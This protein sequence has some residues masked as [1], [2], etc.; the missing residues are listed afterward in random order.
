MS[1][2]SHSI[3]ALEAEYCVGIRLQG[4]SWMINPDISK[5]IVSEF[6]GWPCDIAEFPTDCGDCCRD[7]AKLEASSTAT[8]TSR[9]CM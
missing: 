1:W 4:N 5:T 6:V 2:T 9:R 7:F 3:G 8:S